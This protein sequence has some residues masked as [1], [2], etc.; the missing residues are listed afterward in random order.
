M[1]VLASAGWPAPVRVERMQLGW[2]TR[3]WRV[4]AT[5][6]QHYALRLYTP[7]FELDR[8]RQIA[9][10]EL[11]GIR[12]C[13]VAGMPV[14][15]VLASGEFEGAPFFIQRWL[16]GANLVECMQHRPWQVWSLGRDF[17]R[18][19]ARI[20]A[21]PGGDVGPLRIED[22]ADFVADAQIAASVA[23]ELRTDTLCHHDYHPLNVLVGEC[24]ISAL[25]DFSSM[26]MSDARAD[27]GLTK[28]ILVGGPVPPGPLKPVASAGRGQFLRAW[29]KGYVEVAGSWPLTPLFEAFGAA[30]Y[31]GALTM[32]R[33][34]GRG[35][36]DT[37]GIEKYLEKAR[38]A[39]GL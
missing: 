9:A 2:D 31:L 25:L 8:L 20:H 3:L 28:A 30:F 34:E 38:R 21:T 39:A 23:G 17:G 35:W 5:D 22:W 33:G 12:A 32:L 6:G 10:N 4:E 36:G 27:L 15:E 26:R 29:R 14:P 11:A 19:Q 1:T 37:S 13:H 18:L 16:P 7:R 24:G